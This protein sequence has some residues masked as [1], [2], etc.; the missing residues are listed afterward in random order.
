MGIIYTR[1]QNVHPTA[2]RTDGGLRGTT[3]TTRGIST[4]GTAIETFEPLMAKGRRKQGLK[5]NCRKI[6][7]FQN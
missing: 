4:V 5:N 6:W 3:P 7:W 2:A 1:T